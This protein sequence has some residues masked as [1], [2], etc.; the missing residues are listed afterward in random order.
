MKKW[1]WV[2]FITTLMGCT[3]LLIPPIE[4]NT[5]GN[6]LILTGVIDGSTAKRLNEELEKN[7]LLTTLVLKSIPGS[8]DDESSLTDLHKVIAQSGLTLVVPSDGY[9][10]SGGTDMIL[11]SNYRIIE[12]GACIG[13]HS[14]AMDG[15]GKFI[16][17]SELPRDAKEHKMYL[18]YYR[19]VGIPEAFYWFTLD[20]AGSEDIY[21]MSSE[22]IN[23]FSLSSV[24]LDESKYD[25]IQERFIR[26]NNRLE[27]TFIHGS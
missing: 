11:M 4:F 3:S 15:G 2:F 22:E 13:V 20:K 17:G 16:E 26:C 6:T 25:D 1:Y 23:A 24:Q 7:P 5:Q 9:V 10:A 21:W 27:D 18:D 8:V 14:W 12:S 19:D